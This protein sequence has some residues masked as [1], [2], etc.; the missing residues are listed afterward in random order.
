MNSHHRW[1]GLFL[2]I[3]ICLLVEGLAGAMTA[4]AIPGWYAGLKKP[5]WTP[6]AWVFGPVW[7]FLYLTMAVA[8]WLV[9]SK[10]GLPGASTPL[11]L[12]GVQLIFNF[13]WSWIFFGLHLPGIA[14]LD[15]VLLWLA[16]LATL[17][18]FW[19]VTPAAG[20]LL[21][22]YLTWVSYAATL[23]FAIWRSNW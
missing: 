22:P 16:I 10:L 4:S 18:A 15:I 17:I 7:T 6:P 23:N 3:A 21:V 20:W 14:F 12:F 13:A 2:F 1:L 9:W 11:I 19:R 8:A 5:S